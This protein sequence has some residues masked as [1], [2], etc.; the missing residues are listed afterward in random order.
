M[1]Q[2]DNM[3]HPIHNAQQQMQEA[4]E[5]AAAYQRHP[6]LI[7]NVHEKSK[8]VTI[9]HQGDP[10]AVESAYAAANTARFV[11]NYQLPDKPQAEPNLTSFDNPQ[12]TA[13]QFR[14]P[15]DG[16][17]QLMQDATRHGEYTGEMNNPAT[18]QSGDPNYS[19]QG[20]S[21]PE[22]AAPISTQQQAQPQ[23]TQSQTQPQTQ[24]Q[25]QPQM[26]PQMQ[27]QQMQAQPQQV[28]PQPQMQPQILLQTQPQVQP[29]QM[30][31]MMQPQQT[32]PQMQPQTLQQ[33]QPQMQTQPQTQTQ[34]QAPPQ[35]QKQAPPQT[36]QQA[37]QQIQQG[38]QP[39]QRQETEPTTESETQQT[40]ASDIKP[41]KENKL[42]RLFCCG[43]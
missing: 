35:T 6:E 8:D 9:G 37:P 29:Q 41:K 18:N 10:R 7:K 5:K 38:E 16:N 13:A 39:H 25:T 32:Q 24:S 21:M 26:Q 42:R 31:P 22:G 33:M 14:K 12:A 27:P 2:A 11:E 36:Q 19:A 15:E 17:E 1:S 3:P 23:L 30:Q 40:P 28:Q 20:S 43:A 34:R 4:G